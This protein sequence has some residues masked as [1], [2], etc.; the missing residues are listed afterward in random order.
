MIRDPREVILSRTI[1]EEQEK[2]YEKGMGG[3]DMED[4]RKGSQTV[5]PL[6]QGLA[7]L[8]EGIARDHACLSFPDPHRPV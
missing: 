7:G 3:F 6:Y 2:A 8:G 1:N 5:H 4:D